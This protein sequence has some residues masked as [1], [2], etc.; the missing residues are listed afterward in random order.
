M[1]NNTYSPTTAQV[2]AA[3]EQLRVGVIRKLTTDAFRAY[4]A[5]KHPNW[6]FL[7]YHR[8]DTLHAVATQKGGSRVARLLEFLQKLDVITGQEG[9]K[10]SSNCVE[11]LE[12]GKGWVRMLGTKYDTSGRLEVRYEFF[13]DCGEFGRVAFGVDAIGTGLRASVVS[14]YDSLH[15]INCRVITWLN[16]INHQKRSYH[17]DSMSMH[18]VSVLFSDVLAHLS[19]Y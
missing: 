11:D 7:V 12:A 14:N 8:G 3:L 16:L 4:M 9:Y 18:S 15:R 2:D 19:N 6:E 1:T 10:I 13:A 5:D 17:F